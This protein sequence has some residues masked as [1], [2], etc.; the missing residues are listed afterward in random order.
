MPLEIFI[1]R[2]GHVF[3]KRGLSSVEVLTF[4][5]LSPGLLIFESMI[6]DL[7]QKKDLR[8]LVTAWKQLVIDMR[9][10]LEKEDPKALDLATKYKWGAKELEAL[11]ELFTDAEK[12]FDHP[13]DAT[14]I[15]PN[16]A[17]S[18]VQTM[19]ENA[20][21][22]AGMV[23][24]PVGQG[25]AMQVPAVTNRTLK[26]EAKPPPGQ[27]L[28]SSPFDEP[29]PFYITE[30]AKAVA[31]R[32]LNGKHAFLRTPK[33]FALA[34]RARLVMVGDWGTG[35]DRADIISK[36]MRQALEEAR[37]RQRHVFHLGD[38]YFCGWPK[39]AQ[40]RFLD[41]WPV[42]DGEDFAFSWCLNGN[43]DM[44]CGGH[45]YFDVVLGDPRFAQQGGRSYF[46]LENNEW[47]VIGLDSAYEEWSFGN[48]QIDW[49]LEQRSRAPQKKGLLLSHH[50]PFSDYEGGK[51]SEGL[52]EAAAPLLR[53][54]RTTAWL[55]GHEHRAVV[56]PPRDFKFSNGSKGQLPFGCCIGH[57]GVPAWPTKQRA[58]VRYAL[59][60][61]KRQGIETFGMF[62]F[63]ILD[64]DGPMAWLTLVDE[65]GNTGFSEPIV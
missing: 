23:D 64:I 30:G 3:S 21:V 32:F 56:Y 36:R 11:E 10:A 29:G 7:L 27:R 46:L 34:D 4:A 25:L 54:K 20:Y 8:G 5:C 12:G 38:I 58:S 37:D 26:Q 41:H 60:R 39:E 31:W 52:L 18:F 35:I 51:K 2:S 33:P 48:G 44:Y 1:L 55:W 45:G 61:T 59:E 9:E 62:G 63:G 49:A 24:E 42:R 47:Q 65:E 17:L 53:D 28:L 14:F 57:G 19:F 13:E 50:Q 16:E 22:D 15:P 40:E 43:H 6:A